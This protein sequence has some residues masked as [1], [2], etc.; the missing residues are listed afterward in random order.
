MGVFDDMKFQFKQPFW[1]MDCDHYKKRIV[2]KNGIDHFYSF[3][4]RKGAEVTIVADSTPDIMFRRSGSGEVSA[5]IFGGVTKPLKTVYPDDSYIFGVRLL[6]GYYESL[7]NVA[8]KEVTENGADIKDVVKDTS[9]I[10]RII[11]ESDMAKQIDIFN[12]FFFQED[13]AGKYYTMNN[14][15]LLE[16]LH[17]IFVSGGTVTME[18]LEQKTL[19]SK[20]LIR[21]VFSDFMGEPI[22]K[23]SN[24]IRYQNLLEKL[25]YRD[26]TI[27]TFTDLAQR[28][29]YYDQAHMIHEFDRFTLETPKNY[30]RELEENHFLENIHFV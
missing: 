19:Y 28:T 24:I 4:T 6:P 26:E 15:L 9:A 13:S 1:V 22:K 11:E 2:K 16:V 25:N 17:M 14:A 18:E 7:G 29:G 21:K 23:F 10:V 12:R 20:S 5:N 30:L 8:L 3:H 27:K